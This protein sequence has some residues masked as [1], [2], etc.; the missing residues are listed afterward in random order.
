Q[1]EEALAKEE[2]NK[3]A[4]PAP[5]E[6][7]QQQAPQPT[8]EPEKPKPPE[9]ITLIVSPQDAVTLNYM[10][11]SGTKLTLALRA[12]G[13]DTAFDTEAA[14]LQFLLDT[15]N[16]PVPAKLPYG[17]E[18]RIDKTLNNPMQENDEVPVETK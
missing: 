17:L 6:Q 7:G 2:K 1:E 13:D 18:P 14:T 4:E 10:V 11:S 9:V 5:T 8:P 16:I 3:P 15:Y 12:A